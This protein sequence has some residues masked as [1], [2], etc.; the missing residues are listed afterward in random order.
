MKKNEFLQIV[1][2]ICF[3]VEQ[4]GKTI[5]L[6]CNELVSVNKEYN[7]KWHHEMKHVSHNQYKNK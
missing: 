3:F 7:L 2:H 5:C 4:K 6:I 1:G